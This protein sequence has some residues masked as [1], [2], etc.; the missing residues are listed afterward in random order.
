MALDPRTGNHITIR[1]EPKV[2]AEVEGSIE[3]IFQ[4]LRETSDW[5]TTASLMSM[6]SKGLDVRNELRN[7]R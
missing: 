4:A 6:L 3:Q 5:S 7:A 2:L 1:P